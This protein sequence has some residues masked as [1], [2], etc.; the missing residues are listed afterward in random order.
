MYMG[1]FVEGVFSPVVVAH[2]T[3]AGSMRFC[4]YLDFSFIPWDMTEFFCS[5]D[6]L[7][8]LFSSFFS[9]LFQSELYFFLLG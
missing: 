9:E 8:L 1:L 4:F 3:E 6:S 7:W 5:F 2:G